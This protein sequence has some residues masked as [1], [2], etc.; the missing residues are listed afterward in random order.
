MPVQSILFTGDPS[1]RDRLNQSL[2]N[3]TAHITP[4][5][6]GEHV[7]KIQRALSLLGAT[8]NDNEVGHKQYGPSTANA[9]LA[10]KANCAP[11]L[12]NYA[13][14][15]DNITGKKTTLELDRQIAIFEKEHPATPDPELASGAGEVQIGPVGARGVALLKN[16]YHHCGMEN[17]G[18]RHISTANINTFTNFEE[19]LDLL[20]TR[21]SKHQVIVNHGN[22]FE[23]M[24][25]QWTKGDNYK[26]GTGK[27]IKFFSKISD[28]IEAGTAKSS[29]TD[30]Q[31]SVDSLTFMLG[32]DEKTCVRIANKF[33]A[34]RKKEFWI[35]IRACNLTMELADLYLNAFGAEAVTYH[36]MYLVYVSIDPLKYSPGDSPANYP[37]SK[38]QENLRARVFY[39]PF[40][41]L[42]S[43]AVMVAHHFVRQNREFINAHASSRVET[44]SLDQIQQWAETLIGKWTGAPGRFILPLLWADNER[45]WYCPFEWD[46]LLQTAVGRR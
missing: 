23:G 39:D 1:V 7:A 40:G 12:L 18:Y 42:T 30:Y 20:L 38:N 6:S 34:V 19:L 26:F 45:S 35:H 29:N 31:D 8:I 14:K 22:S 46:R 9:V 21:S 5:S 41:E 33:V 44:F 17:I 4:G 10:F 13:N 16:Y 24:M 32:V 37:Y 28:A 43:L 27:N 3:D 11:P 25:L 15:L 2:E 36:E